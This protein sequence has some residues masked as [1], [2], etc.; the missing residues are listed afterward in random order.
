MVCFRYIIVNTLNRSDNNHNNNNDDDNNDNGDNKNN[1]RKLEQTYPSC[2][3]KVTIYMLDTTTT[4]PNLA[5]AP[6]THTTRSRTFL[7]H[8]MATALT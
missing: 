3:N 7:Q 8:P 1:N 4:A 5:L 2:Q 6:L